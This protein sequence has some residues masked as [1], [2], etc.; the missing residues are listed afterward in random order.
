MKESPA[1][2]KIFADIEVL[3]HL[4]AV[5]SAQKV[6]LV[7][8]VS[9]EELEISKSVR[10]MAVPLIIFSG[11]TSNPLYSDVVKG[12]ALFRDRGCDAIVAVGGGSAIDTAKCIKLFCGMDPARSYLEQKYIKNG[13]PLV[14]VPTTSG[15]GSE[16]TRF[17][18]IYHNGE[19]QSITNEDILPPYV[20]LD[21]SVLKTLPLFQKKC[22]MLDAL[23]QAVESWWSVNSTNESR[24][25]SKQAAELIVKNMDGYLGNI[26]EGNRAMLTAANLSGQAINLAQTT[27]AHAMS[28]KLTSLYRLPHGYAAALCLPH[29]W[30]YMLFNIEKCSDIRGPE[31]LGTVFADISTILGADG[32]PGGIRTFRKLLCTLGITAPKEIQEEDLALLAR[33]VN[34]ARLKNNP[35]PIDQDA[36]LKLYK[37]ILNLK[38]ESIVQSS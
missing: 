27:A 24:A 36:A 21:S 6:L 37:K 17:A 4:L 13:I 3:P 23:C 26:R 28:Y 16:S 11:F 8:D 14:A 1:R 19:K 5:H 34:P 31:Y 7:C 12:A 18:V 20:I 25:L 10:T 35:V 15:T 32:I 22:T 9:F 29:V 38:E 2:Q 30:E 33:S